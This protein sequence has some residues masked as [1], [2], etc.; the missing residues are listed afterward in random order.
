MAGTMPKMI[1]TADEKPMPMANG[2]QLSEVGQAGERR[3][4]VAD[5][6]ADQDAEDAADA[7][8]HDGLEQELPEDLA[9]PGA[10]RLADA[11]LRA[12]VR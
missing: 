2:F 4:R 7:R 6:D 5:A 10:E 8:E 12:S 1:P 3:D 9:A 11:D